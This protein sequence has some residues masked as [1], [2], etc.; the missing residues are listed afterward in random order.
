MASKGQVISARGLSTDEF[1]RYSRPERYQTPER[2]LDRLSWY[3]LEKLAAVL[4]ELCRGQKNIIH[5]DDLSNH[6]SGEL[7][8]T[9][10]IEPA[11]IVVLEGVYA[12]HDSIQEFVDFGIILIA[13]HEVLP[14]RVVFRDKTE[15]GIDEK[16]VLDWNDS[17]SHSQR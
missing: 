7:D 17:R 12:L 9:R 14:H 11:D 10:D 8:L 1:R 16:T 2:F 4:R 15:R 3:D 5:L 13:H 6:L